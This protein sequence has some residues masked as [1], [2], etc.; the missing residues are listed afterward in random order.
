MQQMNAPTQEQM[1]DYNNQ[2]QAQISNAQ[3]SHESRQNKE[4]VISSC[5]DKLPGLDGERDRKNF[6]IKVYSL[7][8]LMLGVTSAWSAYVYINKGLQ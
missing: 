8:F 4:G 7:I 3:K 5:L 1:A 6:I 2:M